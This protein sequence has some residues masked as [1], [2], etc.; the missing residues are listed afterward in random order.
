M[1]NSMDQ[2]SNEQYRQSAIT[3][4]ILSGPEGSCIYTGFLRWIGIT[5]GRHISI[6]L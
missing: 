2:G 3:K 1:P 4:V 6:V 5:N